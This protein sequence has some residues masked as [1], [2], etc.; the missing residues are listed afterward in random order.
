MAR[1]ELETFN[2][3]IKLSYFLLLMNASFIDMFVVFFYLNGAEQDR[4]MIM[5]ACR[6]N[7]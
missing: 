2:W 1:N 5:I 4:L 3:K 6:K 7:D